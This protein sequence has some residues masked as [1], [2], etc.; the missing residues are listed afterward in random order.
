M[1][2]LHNFVVGSI[3]YVLVHALNENVGV[4][5]HGTLLAHIYTQLTRLVP[6]SEI[7]QQKAS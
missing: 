3:M 1:F 7:I 6:S 5:L 4:R 2:A